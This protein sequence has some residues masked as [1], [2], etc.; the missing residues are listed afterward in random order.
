[1]TVEA[2]RRRLLGRGRVIRRSATQSKRE[3]SYDLLT[4]LTCWIGDRTTRIFFLGVTQTN[5]SLD[6]FLYFT[7]EI[8]STTYS[9]MLWNVLLF[10]AFKAFSRFWRGKFFFRSDEIWPRFSW[11]RLM[12]IS[13]FYRLYLTYD[14]TKWSHCKMLMSRFIGRFLNLKPLKLVENALALKCSECFSKFLNLV[15]PN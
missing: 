10:P 14:I 9:L 13:R 15:D 11:D 7:S 6:A 1:M 3:K 4:H 8:C 5:F 2:D 12:R